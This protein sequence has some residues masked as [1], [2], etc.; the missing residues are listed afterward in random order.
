MFGIGFSEF[1]IVIIAA[2]LFLGPEKLPELGQKLGRLLREF[3]NLKLD[4]TEKFYRNDSQKGSK[5]KGT[6]KNHHD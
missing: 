3:R 1:I 6:S 2:L 4:F 5:D